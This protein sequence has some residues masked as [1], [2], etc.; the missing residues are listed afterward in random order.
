MLL[1]GRN[2]FT[3]ITGNKKESAKINLEMISA[4][5]YK[6]F[7]SYS[8]QFLDFFDN[9]GSFDTTKQSEY[10]LFKQGIRASIKLMFEEIAQKST[11]SP[12]ELRSC[13]VMI[14][15]CFNVAQKGRGKSGLQDIAI[16]V[17][18]KFEILKD[19][20]SQ[21]VS[22]DAAIRMK[23]FLAKF[24]LGSASKSLAVSL[25]PFSAGIGSIVLFGITFYEFS[26]NKKP[27]RQSQKSNRK[28][29]KNVK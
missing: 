16:R 17:N 20:Q 8:D 25:A 10:N 28:G 19:S 14:L 5:T 9:S 13:E 4:K 2:L 29:K 3:R 15:D 27:V 11:L 22:S 7:A 24:V 18:S 12:S 1:H 23:S 6:L 26:P 21:A